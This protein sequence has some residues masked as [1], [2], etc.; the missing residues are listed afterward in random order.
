MEQQFGYRR[1]L[2]VVNSLALVCTL[3]MN[4]LANVL[5]FNGMQTGQI[6]DGIVNLFV[7]AGMTFAIWGVI[8]VLLVLLVIYQ[9]TT[10]KKRIA[11]EHPVGSI[12]WWFSL[13]CIANATWIVL[14]HWQY[15]LRSLAVMLILLVSLIVMYLR[16]RLPNASLGYRIGIML[17]ISVYLGWITVATIANVTSVLVVY[18][19]GRFGLT[20]AFWTTAVLVV[21]IIINVLII[22]I[23]GDMWFA[24]VGLWSLFGIYSKRTQ[25]Q[26]E[27][28]LP[29]IMTALV[30]M[31]VIT[32]AIL[33]HLFIKGRRVARGEA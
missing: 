32:V 17:P 19:W 2:I 27:P 8:Y 12:S 31:V 3:V 21:A 18:Q 9:A 28:V 24:I 11:D 7:P 10:L 15:I 26:V 1:W 16:C 5:P 6:S 30:G 29:V 33:I 22:V 20:E 14:W 23:Q 25:A 13:S 4:A